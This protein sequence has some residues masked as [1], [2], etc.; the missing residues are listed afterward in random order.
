MD[1]EVRYFSRDKIPVLHHSI[2]EVMGGPYEKRCKPSG[3]GLFAN[4]KL[5]TLVCWLRIL[6]DKISFSCYQPKLTTNFP[7]YNLFDPCLQRNRE[8]WSNVSKLTANTDTWPRRK[9]APNVV[10]TLP[11]FGWFSK[12]LNTLLV[13]AGLSLSFCLFEFRESALISLPDFLFRTSAYRRFWN[14]FLIARYWE[15]LK[16]LLLYTS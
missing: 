15:F 14:F 6:K 5:F 11:T 3:K 9:Q 13:A 16:E 4:R 1:E 10:Y 7:Q 2:L 12:S 8:N